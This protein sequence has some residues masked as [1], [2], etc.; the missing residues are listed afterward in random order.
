MKFF[1]KIK[2]SFREQIEESKMILKNKWDQ[3]ADQGKALKEKQKNMLKK[4]NKNE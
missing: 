3:G 2:D 4:R 1:D